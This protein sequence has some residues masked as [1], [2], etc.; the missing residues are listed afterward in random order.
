MQSRHFY[1]ISY[2]LGHSEVAPYRVAWGVGER[3]AV[4]PRVREAGLLRPLEEPA[5]CHPPN[6]STRR[7]REG[8]RPA[9]SREG[10]G[11]GGR[12]GSGAARS[13][14]VSSTGAAPRPAWPEVSR[15]PLPRARGRVSHRRVPAWRARPG[16]ELTVTRCQAAL[17]TATGRLGV[18]SW[19]GHTREGGPS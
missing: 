18:P 13:A 3:T 14:C 2:P 19:K 8:D 5:R 4:G 16:T 1:V 15:P 11:W 12:G 6:F 10:G 17:A 7:R 9:E